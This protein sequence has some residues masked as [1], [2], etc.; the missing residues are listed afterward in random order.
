[1]PFVME[2]SKS[3]KGASVSEE[4]VLFNGSSVRSSDLPFV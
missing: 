3:K 2:K 1:M 4:F